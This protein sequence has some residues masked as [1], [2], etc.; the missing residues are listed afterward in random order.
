MNDNNGNQHKLNILMSQFNP[1]S[2]FAEQYRIIRTNI[3]Y[4]SEGEDIQSIVVTSVDLGEGKTTTV[5]NLG[6]VL[7]QQG[8]RVLIVDADIRKPSLHRFFDKSNYR[9][10]TNILLDRTSLDG[11]VMPTTIKNLDLLPSGPIPKRDSDLLG[12]EKMEQLMEEIK[13]LY[14]IVIMDSPP[15]IENAD[16]Q[17]LANIC[18]GSIMVM[19]SGIT[20]KD[21]A[22]IAKN[23]LVNCKSK[24][25][26]AMLNGKKD[27]RLVL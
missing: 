14:D 25:V 3:Q 1:S 4:S 17:V 19:K 11:V 5:A 16:A 18:D 15:I 26:G 9:G 13:K 7:A 21:Q 2:K 12:T 27:V 23:T 10:L 24:L 20:K 6:V 22:I 8:K